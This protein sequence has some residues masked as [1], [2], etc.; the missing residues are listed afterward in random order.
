[1]DGYSEI[2]PKELQ[3]QVK[4]S[5]NGEYNLIK[6]VRCHHHA[7][8]DMKQQCVLLRFWHLNSQ[9]N[10]TIF[11]NRQLRAQDT[12]RSASNKKSIRWMFC[13]RMRV[14]D[15]SD[16][17]WRVRLSTEKNCFGDRILYSGGGGRGNGAL[18]QFYP[19]TEESLKN[20]LPD[21]EARLVS[22]APSILSQCF[23]SFQ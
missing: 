4:A 13:L 8:Q 14:N 17:Q 21:R 11:W 9:P 20:A 12:L 23:H 22:S 5:G 10:S 7:H 2:A 3:K 16:Y 15:A 6:C 1:M 19:T 18:W